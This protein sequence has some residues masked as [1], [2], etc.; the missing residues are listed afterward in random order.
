MDTSLNGSR[1]DP[2]TA[3]HPGKWPP[4]TK[5]PA[6]RAPAGTAG[7]AYQSPSSSLAADN[8]SHDNNNASA[9]SMLLPQDGDAS[10]AVAPAVTPQLPIYIAQ[11]SAKKPESKFR[12]PNESVEHTADNAPRII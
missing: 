9:V 5:A 7:H 6:L 1:S 3:T 2:A 12:L 10:G 4:T 11:P 8:R